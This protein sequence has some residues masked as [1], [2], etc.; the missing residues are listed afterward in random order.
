MDIR[1]LL[2]MQEKLDQHI[3]KQHKLPF[4]KLTNA[5]LA[6]I[7]ELSEVVNDEQ[8]FKYWKV[9][10]K[11][12]ETVLEEVADFTHFLAHLSNRFKLTA[13]E[14][15]QRGA[16][17]YKEIDEHFLQMHY[18]TSMIGVYPT[19]PEKQKYVKELWSLFKG[20]LDHLGFSHK[21]VYE[22]YLQKHERNYQRQLEGY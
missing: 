4:I 18:V 1:Q 3:M 22:A 21:Q 8:S 16:L 20:L 12:K 9:N 15:T 7:T 19:A 5:V 13:D 11:P 14:I 6:T 10:N 2:E 17:K